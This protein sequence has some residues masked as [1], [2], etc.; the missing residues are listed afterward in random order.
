MQV[1]VIPVCDASCEQIDEVV[2]EGDCEEGRSFFFGRYSR[3]GLYLVFIV[4]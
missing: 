2:L 4:A 3:P 1:T